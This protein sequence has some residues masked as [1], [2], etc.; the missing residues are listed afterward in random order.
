M[1]KVIA[2]FTLAAVCC[3]TGC[4]NVTQ[5]YETD[6]RLQTQTEKGFEEQFIT[7]DARAAVYNGEY[8]SFDIPEELNIQGIVAPI[9]GNSFVVSTNNDFFV[10]ADIGYNDYLEHG[11]EYGIYTLGGEYKT[12]IPKYSEDDSQIKVSTILYCNDEYILYDKAV[13]NSY[14][15][16]ASTELV[17]VYLLKLDDMTEKR[18]Y[19]FMQPYATTAVI[20]GNAVY[21]ERTGEKVW[22][23]GVHKSM[24]SNST[25][26]KYDIE[27]G[28]LE[29]FCLNAGSPVIYKDKP[30]FY[31]GDGTFVSQA[32]PLFVPEEYGLTAKSLKIF[33]SDEMAY[34]YYSSADGKD[35]TILGYIK[36]GKQ[37]NIFRAND[38][39]SVY[40]V[41]FA[42]GYA[43]WDCNY[44]AW[45]SKS[46]P[47][48]YSDEKKSVIV[49]EDERS[50]YE[51]LI[52]DGKIYFF[53]LNEYNSGYER[54]LVLD[55]ENI[56]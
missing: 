13:L 19:R 43:V 10:G 2:L 35:C 6:E 8:E 15:S 52:H 25:I 27:K 24:Y 48:F 12:L 47:M 16:I 50:N 46:F 55:T 44:F 3:L 41:S 31:V 34:S 11:G 56:K 49:I 45:G 38:I 9:G 39:I 4:S 5:I 1:K 7:L 22:S 26:V 17:D 30:A 18:I 28:E 54:A 42:D 29:D 53:E 33:P 37:F 51:S 32:E 14:G 20:C 21:L 36:D 40:D 23:D